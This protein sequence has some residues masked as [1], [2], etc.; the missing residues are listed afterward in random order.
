MHDLR[1]T[2]ATQLEI[3]EAPDAVVK[4]TLNHSDKRGVTALYMR[5]MSDESLRLRM[6]GK[7]LD[8]LSAQYAELAK[9]P[10]ALPAPGSAAG[11]DGVIRTAC[12]GDIS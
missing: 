1:R 9:P 6:L 2:A 4:A 10:L 3:L 12:R 5:L 8:M 11:D 7:W